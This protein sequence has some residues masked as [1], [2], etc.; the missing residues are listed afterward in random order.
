MTWQERLLLFLYLLSKCGLSGTVSVLCCHDMTQQNQFL[1]C[2][3]S[4]I[5]GR[6]YCQCMACNLPTTTVGKG[7]VRGSSLPLLSVYAPKNS[8]HL[9]C[10]YMIWLVRYSNYKYMSCQGQLLLSMS[11]HAFCQ[12][13]TV[14]V[15]AVN[16]WPRRQCSLPY[17]H[18]YMAYK[19]AS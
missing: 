14:P 5:Y 12:T 13:G 15:S 4:L 2:H 7:P 18:Q 3:I 1:V 17:Q 10:Q 19:R 6:F 11:V 16:I 9:Y 8:S